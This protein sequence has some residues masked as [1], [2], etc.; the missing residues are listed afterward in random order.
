MFVLS[1][2]YAASVN[3]PYTIQ[4]TSFITIKKN[5]SISFFLTLIRKYLSYNVKFKKGD[6]FEIFS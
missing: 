3:F 2:I 5:T 6:I 1:S 4:T